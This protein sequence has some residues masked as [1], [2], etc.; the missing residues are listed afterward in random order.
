MS[1]DYER[2]YLGSP[3]TVRGLIEQLQQLP[4]EVMDLPAAVLDWLGGSEPIYEIVI[5]RQTKSARGRAGNLSAQFTTD[6]GPRVI[7]GPLGF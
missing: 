5:D 2:V 3:L 4:E 6:K 1:E 7:L